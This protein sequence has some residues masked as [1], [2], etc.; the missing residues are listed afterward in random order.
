[1]SKAAHRCGVPRSTLYRWIN[2][3][4]PGDENSLIDKSQKPIN[5][6]KKITIEIEK[7]ILSIRD[8]HNFVPQIVSTHLPRNHEVKLSPPTVWRVLNRY[9]IKPLKKY[10][11]SKKLSVI[12]VL[13][14]A[15]ERKW[16][17]RAANKVCKVGK[18]SLVLRREL[19]H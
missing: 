8:K 18:H 7:I 10:K 5:L 19:S 15:I 4:K 3:Y 6:A 12:A 16:M 11:K 17:F 9:A 1:M 14:L 2:R 13:S